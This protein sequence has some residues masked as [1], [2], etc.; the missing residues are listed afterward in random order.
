M[1]EIFIGLNEKKKPH[2]FVGFA[3]INPLKIQDEIAH[4]K[5]RFKPFEIPLESGRRVHD[6]DKR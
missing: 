6:R 2:K 3:Q 5:Q 1:S 4:Y